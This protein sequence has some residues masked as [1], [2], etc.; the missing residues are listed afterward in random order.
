M[1]ITLQI[2]LF[3]DKP[4]A[5][6]LK[7]TVERFNVACNW[8]AGELFSRKLA[9]RIEAQRLLYHEIRQRFELTAQTT[10]LAIRRTCE[11]YKRDKEIRPK[12]RKHAAIT[13]DSRVMKFVGPDKVNLWT[14]A[15]RQVIPILM[16]KYQEERFTTAKGEADL[17]LRHDGKWFLLVTVKLPDG[18]LIPAT[19]FIGIDFGVVNIASRFASSR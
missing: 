16:G 13:Y 2:Q 3:P 6:A 11:A 10:I 4:Q 7:A 5:A 19:D 18:T 15:G 1:D 12:F 8:I 14:L 17:V 9:N